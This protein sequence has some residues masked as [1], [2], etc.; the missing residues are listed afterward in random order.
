MQPS[1]S[2]DSLGRRT[3]EIAV[4][5]MIAAHWG[6]TR[7]MPYPEHQEVEEE[8]AQ[9]EDGAAHVRKRAHHR[10]RVLQR[11]RQVLALP[12]MRTRECSQEV[13]SVV[14]FLSDAQ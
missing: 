8:E 2:R 11:K 13:L 6:D 1:H 10:A 4:L 14:S 7:Q 3:T 12:F 9:L 5:S